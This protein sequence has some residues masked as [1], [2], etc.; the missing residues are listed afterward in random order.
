MPSNMRSLFKRKGSG[1]KAINDP[2]VDPDGGSTASHSSNEQHFTSG[3]SGGGIPQQ[4]QALPEQQLQM[5]N[6]S[7]QGKK[8][9]TRSRDG[10]PIITSSGA[11]FF[12]ASAV[13]SK[14]NYATE[15]FYSK[16]KLEFGGKERPKVRPSARTSAFGGAPRYDWMDIV[17]CSFV[18]SSKEMYCVC[19]FFVVLSQNYCV[20]LM[21]HSTFHILLFLQET[22]AAIK[23]QAAY[24]RM[25]VQNDLDAR[26]L[27]TPGMRNRRAQRRAQ[28]RSR[29]ASTNADV[30]FPFNLCGVGLLFGDGTLED[31]KIVTKLEKKKLEKK[32]IEGAKE[33][34]EKRKFRM[35][36]KESQHLE[37]GIEVV[38]SF[39]DEEEDGV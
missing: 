33:D 2:A 17:R 23:L 37:E 28:Q 12:A 34:E 35:R 1:K 24:R 20:T 22:T 11:D 5:K 8:C 39:D 15:G 4:Q 38:E 27:S 13:S 19:S 18:H 31:E 25:Q 10:V 29:H 26:G 16:S 30:P 36:K 14:N 9:D 32:K 7:K 6:V 21:T 3:D